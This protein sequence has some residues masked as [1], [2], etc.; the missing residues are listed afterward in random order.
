MSSPLQNYIYQPSVIIPVLG[1][2]FAAIAVAAALAFVVPAISRKFI[3]SPKATRLGDHIKFNKMDR[4][5]RI[6]IGEDNLHTAVL[7][8]RG[9]DLRFNESAQQQQYLQAREN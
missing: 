2:I 8:V 1:F 4:D 9:V 7:S 3:P 6:I 5:G